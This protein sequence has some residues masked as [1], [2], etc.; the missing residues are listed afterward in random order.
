MDTRH[1]GPVIDAQHVH[2]GQTNN[3]LTHARRVNFH[4][5]SRIWRRREPPDSLSL[6][7]PSGI[8][9]TPLISEAPVYKQYDY[10]NTKLFTAAESDPSLNVKL[11]ELTSGPGAAAREH[12]AAYLATFCGVNVP[13]PAT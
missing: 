2:L 7:T 3:K 11:T 1:V 4:R 6:Y 12:V 9:Y 10:D 8:P 5:G 13:P